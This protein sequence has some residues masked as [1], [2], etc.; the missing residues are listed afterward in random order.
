MEDKR[1]NKKCIVASLLSLLIITHQTAALSV[2]AAT[3]I[4][5]SSGDALSPDTLI[6]TPGNV[7]FY[8]ITPDVVNKTTKTGFR[9]FNDFILDKGDVANFIFKWYNQKLEERDTFPWVVNLETAD[10]E[11]FVAAIKNQAQIDGVINALKSVQTKADTST[12]QFDPNGHLIMLAPNGV[13]IGPSGVLNVGELSI[14]TPKNDDAYNNFI[15]KIGEARIYGTYTEHDNEGNSYDVSGYFGLE[16]GTLTYDPSIFTIDSAKSVVLSSDKN[17]VGTILGRGNLSINTGTLENSGRIFNGLSDTTSKIV[18]GDLD[19]KYLADEV[20]NSLV[21][22]SDKNADT[23]IATNNGVQLKSGSKL[24]NNGKGDLTITNTGAAG[25]SIVG[26]LTNHNG[27]LAVTNSGAGGTNI[28]GTVTN[29]GQALSIENTAGALSVAKNA[30]VTSN[31]TVS[32]TTSDSPSFSVKNSGTGMTIAGNLVN[33]GGNAKIENTQGSLTVTSDGKIT[34]NT[35]HVNIINTDTAATSKL[36]IAGNVENHGYTTIEN[37]GGAGINVTGTVENTGNT[38]IQN[39]G[40]GGITFDSTANVVN[41]GET[42]SVTN[43]GA[44]GIIVKGKITGDNEAQI[45]ITNHDSD[46]VIGDTSENNNY[47][48]TDGNVDIYVD[49]GGSV[50]NSG[51]A[52]TLIKNSKELKIQA[53]DGTIGSDADSSLKSRDLTKSINISSGG[54]VIAVSELVNS[55]SEDDSIVNL[56]SLDSD[57][58]IDQIRSDGKVILLTDKTTGTNTYNIISSG[59][60]RNITGKTISVISSGSIGDRSNPITFLQKDGTFNSSVD[61]LEYTPNV[62][63]KVEMLAN[64]GNINIKGADNY[65]LRLIPVE[66]EEGKTE[67]V[68]E[69]TYTPSD[70]NI[71]ALVAK[72]GNI[73]AEFSGNTYIDGVTASGNVDLTNHGKY[74]VV[75]NLGTVPAYDGTN[76][77]SVTSDY[78]GGYEN[79]HPTSAKLSAFDV[80]NIGEVA[81]DNTVSDSTIVVKN[82]TI[83]GQGAGRPESSQDLTLVADHAYADGYEFLMGKDRNENGKTYYQINPATTKINNATD[84][85]VPISVRAKAVRPDD[86]GNLYIGTDRRKYY[87]GGSSQENDEGYDGKE[88]TTPQEDDDN[89]VTVFKDSDDDTD[90]DTDTDLDAD[91]DSDSDTDVDS[92]TDTDADSDTDTDNDQGDTDTDTDDDL[93]DTDSDDDQGDTDTD[94]D[95]G[96]TDTDDDQGDTDTDDDQGDTDTDDDQGDTDTDNDHDNID[97][98]TDTD[99]DHGH[100]DDDTDTDDDPG[101]LDTDTDTDDDHGSLDTD[102]DTDADTDDDLEDLLNYIHKGETYDTIKTISNIKDIKPM[103][104]DTIPES[105]PQMYRVLDLAGL[106]FSTPVKEVKDLELLSENSII[107]THN[108]NV[109]VGDII[110]VRFVY[111]DIDVEAQTKVKS[112][113]KKT[114]EAKFINLDKVNANRIKYLCLCCKNK[115]SAQDVNKL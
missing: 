89:L 57:L 67:Y 107:L 30:T 31:G 83:K 16:D 76:D 74:L 54:N 72:N 96:D 17:G 29:S 32:D 28:S 87:Y 34:G 85:N 24:V 81:D 112:I 108:N 49:R 20:F 52:K 77:S 10:I 103:P 19:S 105:L 106:Q 93:S 42:V 63:N 15:N 68:E 102:T 6:S 23:L 4:T 97:T 36:D 41:H 61:V 115:F 59:S 98:D 114:L 27:N 13:V 78:F 104:N 99:D 56:A 9:K 92:D 113:N 46:I 21:N 2:F 51:V 91:I 69:Y 12:G 79:L 1:L 43:S 84:E 82:G 25:I 111:K 88:G 26:D 22:T 37:K 3:T 110:P 5:N 70:T 65:T 18:H 75:N 95:Q 53:F 47:L 33:N 90:I 50:L 73:K 45:S 64:K 35:S 39:T 14:L 109:K 11:T 44:G 86:L 60:A 40:A 8:N 100:I 80:L 94:D 66:T 62:T 55:T 7:G 48:S 38:V 71:G 101:I 58:K